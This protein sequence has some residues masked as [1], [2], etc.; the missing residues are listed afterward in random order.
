MT[1]EPKTVENQEKTEY[2]LLE[3]FI[4]HVGHTLP[5]SEILRQVWGDEYGGEAEYLRVYVGRLRRKI[6]A[7]P[8]NPE[9]FFTEHGMG[10]RFGG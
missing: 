9:Y 10:Y 7:D 4:R 5:H 2:N 1:T 8:A 6:E 3:Y